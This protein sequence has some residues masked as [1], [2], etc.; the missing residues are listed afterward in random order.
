MSGSWREREPDQG[1][2]TERDQ[3]RLRAEQPAAEHAEDDSDGPD[4]EPLAGPE[5]QVGSL[6]E[7]HRRLGR[8]TV[9]HHLLAQVEQ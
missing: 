1:A 3:G 2:G 8:L 5:G 6:D 4:D 9:L 7:R